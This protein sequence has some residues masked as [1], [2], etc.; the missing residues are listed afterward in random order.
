MLQKV[1][2]L[3]VLFILAA[4]RIPAQAPFMKNYQVKEGLPSNYTYF[5]AQDSKGYIWVGSDVGVS[6]FDGH[7]FTNFTTAHGLSDNE[8]FSM[9][10][11]HAGRIWFATLNGKPCFYENGQFYN[12]SNHAF[13]KQCNLQGVVLRLFED[14]DHNIVYVSPFQIVT[15]HPGLKSKSMVS[16]P[17][18]IAGA[19]RN[20]SGETGFLS[21][22]TINLQDSSGHP[23]SIPSP[24]I[25]T[26]IFIDHSGDTIYFTSRNR[27]FL[28]DQR[29]GKIAN[30]LLELEG[31]TEIIHIKSQKNK[32]WVGTRSGMLVY[33][34]KTLQP[35]RKLLE[36]F[37]VPRFF[38]DREGGLWFATFEQGIFY[39]PEPDINYF[40]LSQNWSNNRITC[41]SR[42]KKGRLWIGTDGGDYSVFDGKKLITKD[43]LQGVVK[44]KAIL[45]IRHLPDG[46]TMLVGKMGT[47]M[48]KNGQEKFLYQRASDLNIDTEG[49]FWTGMMGLCFIP[50]DDIPHRLFPPQWVNTPRGERY[51]QIRN[52]KPLLTLRIEKIEFDNLGKLWLGT[53]TGLYTYE[54]QSGIQTQI[55][56]YFVRDMLTDPVSRQLWVLTE[57]NGLFVYQNGKATDSIAVVNYGAG[58][59]CRDLCRDEQ[60]RFWIGSAGGLFCVEGQPGNLH[61]KNYWGVSGLGNEKVNAVE[62][63]NGFVYLGKDDGLLQIPES[64][65]LEPALPPLVNLTRPGQSGGALGGPLVLSFGDAPLSIEFQGISFKESQNVRYRYRM[66]GLDDQWYSTTHRAVEYASL[67]PGKYRFEVLAANSSGAASLLPAVLDVVVL[68]PFWMKTWFWLLIVGLLIAGVVVYIKWREKKLRRQFAIERQLMETHTQNAELQRKNADLKML[69]LRLQMNP[70]FIFNALNT[71]KGYYSQD[72][73]VEANSFISKF[74]RLLRLNLDYSD[75][76]I[77]LDQE[78]DL[79]KT[80]IQLSQIRYPE[81]ISFHLVVDQE[82]MPHEVMIPSMLLQPFVENAVIHGIV[83]DSAPGNIEIRIRKYENFIQVEIKDDGVGRQHQHNT[84]HEPHKPLATQITLERLRLLGAGNNALEIQDIYDDK[85]APAGTN[86]I[87]QLPYQL[88]QQ[89]D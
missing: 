45:N 7:T 5:V 80:Y 76:M 59:I 65:L 3:T 50:G 75:A 88:H 21:A 17:K 34:A 41:L 6:R 55:L 23:R 18:G 58:V 64:V 68:P 85:G 10:E 61:I 39:I 15:I 48:I 81:K 14:A 29:N 52:P 9:L 47:L 57:S 8:I 25:S 19:W 74:A 54:P 83:P 63:T 36:G 62:V 56:P 32:I 13:L 33:D 77:P 12:E 78:I 24:A 79:L 37:A 60:G 86:I 4:L 2:I 72:K 84:L 44:N 20:R 43:I 73:M 87:L 53:S 67:R 28:L 69:A 27:V 71:I 70:H 82:I 38:E 42:D 1:I 22:L 40:P 46:T 49:N 26:P 51:Y 30:P 16:V 35:E 31:G 89:H 11:D 66:T